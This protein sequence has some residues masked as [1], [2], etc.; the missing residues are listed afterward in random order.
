MNIVGNS[1]RSFSFHKDHYSISV[2]D[3]SKSNDF[4]GGTLGLREIDNAGLGP[5]FRWYE[6]DDKVQIHLIEGEGNTI[7]LPKATHIALN[8]SDFD[9]FSAFLETL[10][11]PF[12][13]WCGETRM[14][15]MR[16]DGIR[17]IYLQ[18]PDAYWIE[19]NDNDVQ[20]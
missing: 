17:Q 9:G 20:R 10:N 11:F 3:L 16:P 12:E 19:V 5:K 15:N 2:K 4:Y 14:S 7:L 13:N 18:D 6:L 1:I 8:T